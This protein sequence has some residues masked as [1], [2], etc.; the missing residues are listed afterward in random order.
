M[1]KAAF[2]RLNLNERA[3]VMGSG[4]VFQWEELVYQ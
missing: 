4:L 1:K 2:S 3:P